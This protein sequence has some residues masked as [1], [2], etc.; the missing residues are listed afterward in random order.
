MDFNL[1]FCEESLYK[2][3]IMPNGP[4]CRQLFKES[5][6]TR[7]HPFKGTELQWPEMPG[8]SFSFK[9]MSSQN[10]YPKDLGFVSDVV[11]I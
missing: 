3:E 2:D 9:D 1:S 4:W 8:W 6:S 10:Y 11:N 7:S 5:I